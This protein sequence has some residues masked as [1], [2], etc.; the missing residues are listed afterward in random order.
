MKC[1]ICNFNELEKLFTKI[2]KDQKLYQILKCKN[3]KVVQTFP[4]EINS[5]DLYEK[6]Y[7]EK[8]TDRGYNGYT[9]ENIKKTLIQTWEF[10]LKDLDFYKYEKE[11]FKKNSKPKLLDIGCASGF[12]LEYIQKRNWEV[13]G[14]EIS[15]EMADFA[16]DQFNLNVW[17]GDFL[18][19]KTDLSFD[20]ITMWASIEHFSDP[21]KV[22]EKIAQLLKTKGIFIFST[23]RWG[24]LAKIKKEN[25]RF[26][27]VPEHLYFFNEK[28]LEKILKSLN[29]KLISYITYGSG[30]TK[31]E[32]ASL[33]YKIFKL[34]FDKLVKIINM[35]DMLA[36][37][38]IK[39]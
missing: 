34:T 38:F 35:G 19:Y 8:R 27:N 32:N 1:G 26:M 5:K 17:N 39:D 14:V 37:I 36:M 29:F 11:I 6:D 3:C 16:K 25:W 2:G 15:K 33:I 12:F 31:K 23:C 9:S 7:F 20:C 13:Y 4:R 22:F 28:Q 18:E 10:N 30:F 21:I 24:F